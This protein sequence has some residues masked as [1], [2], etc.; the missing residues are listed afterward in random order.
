MFTD[1]LIAQFQFLLRQT[2]K[3]LDRSSQL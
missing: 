2:N 3:S 1:K